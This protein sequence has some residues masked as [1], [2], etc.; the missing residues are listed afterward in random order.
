MVATIA[1]FVSFVF[2][3]VGMLLICAPITAALIHFDKLNAIRVCVYT[4]IAGSAAWTALFWDTSRP[5][6]SLLPHIA[7]GVGCSFG[8]ALVFCV[9]GGITIRSSRARFAAS[10]K[11]H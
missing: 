2:G 11:Y 3:Y 4:T 6:R 7:V 10:C 5:V 9:V 1:F 8:V